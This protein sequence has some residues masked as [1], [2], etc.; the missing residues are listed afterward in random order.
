MIS[1]TALLGRA[2]VSPPCR[3]RVG[4]SGYREHTC[5]ARRTTRPIP[6]EMPHWRPMS[7]SSVTAL[8]MWSPAYCE[9]ISCAY[10]PGHWHGTGSTAATALHRPLSGRPGQGFSALP[11]VVALSGGLRD[12][13]FPKAT[14]V[15][16]GAGY[17]SVRAR[18]VPYRP[19][20]RPSALPGPLRKEWY[21]NHR[22][23]PCSAAS[24]WA[25]MSTC[26]PSQ[27]RY[28]TPSSARVDALMGGGLGPRPQRCR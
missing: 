6:G 10:R 24:W 17:S 25:S 23:P 4:P 7:N 11:G 16:S 26:S 28:S 9:T 20:H 2:R 1:R 21:T 19:V 13:E 8:L 14:L 5:A 3:R 18:A 22:S 12:R 15:S 27:A